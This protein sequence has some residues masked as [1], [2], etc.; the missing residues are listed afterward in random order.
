MPLHHAPDLDRGTLVACGRTVEDV[1][2]N[3]DSKLRGQVADTPIEEFLLWH[4]LLPLREVGACP[5]CVKEIKAKIA[6]DAA[7]PQ[8]N[9]Q[10]AAIPESKAGAGPDPASR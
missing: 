3:K 8:S 5:G 10:T 4:G 6:A 7:P 9:V 2:N 1:L